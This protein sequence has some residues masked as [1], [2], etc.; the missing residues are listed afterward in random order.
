M[1]HIGWRLGR[2]VYGR[3]PYPS[4]FA[5][6]VCAMC[7]CEPRCG[8]ACGGEGVLGR[9]FVVRRG[10]AVIIII[11]IG[12]TLPRGELCVLPKSVLLFLLTI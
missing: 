10:K 9:C 5:A 3:A 6:V 4:F 8:P 2:S 1:G 12:S 7:R 11:I